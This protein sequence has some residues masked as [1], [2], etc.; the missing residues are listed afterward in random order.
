MASAA[1]M[2]TAGVPVE[3]N[4][5]TIFWAMMALLPIPVTMARPS[6]CSS[7]RTASAKPASSPLMSCSTAAA[8]VPMVCRASARIASLSRD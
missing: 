1:C 7:T 8:S 3:L 5:A 6:I 2:K 4:V